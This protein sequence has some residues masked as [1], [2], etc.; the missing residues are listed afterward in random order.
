[1]LRRT[2]LNAV[3]LLADLTRIGAVAFPAAARRAPPS[4]H[5]T[6]EQMVIA[7]AAM[8]LLLAG[9]R[10]MRDFWVG[11]LVKGSSLP[12]SGRPTSST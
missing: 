7:I 11:D 1:M 9:V 10:L 2:Y 8:G 3:R 6:K 5:L 12:R 4:G